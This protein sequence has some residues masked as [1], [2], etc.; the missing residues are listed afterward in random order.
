MVT[1]SAIDASGIVL[2]GNTSVS[3]VDGVANF[4][5]LTLSKPGQGVQLVLSSPGLAGEQIVSV[6]AASATQFVIS[7]PT[8]ISAGGQFVVTVTA[9]DNA[10][11]IADLFNGPVSVSLGTNPVGAVLGGVT[12][13]NAVNGVAQFFLSLSKSGSGFVLSASGDGLNGSTPAF[14]VGAVSRLLFVLPPGGVTAGVPFSAQV[15]AEDSS[16]NA[17]TNFN[18]VVTLTTGPN[19][20]L[21]S[22]LGSTAFLN[23]GTTGKPIT[24]QAVNGVSQFSGL[25]LDKDGTYTLAATS[26]SAVGGFSAPF[27]VVFNVPTQ[28]AVGPPFSTASGTSFSG[29]V[30]GSPFSTTVTVED[31]FG[32]AV[33]TFNGPLSLALGNNPGGATLGGSTTVS[34]VGGVATFA[35]LT[36]DKPGAGYTLVAK[37]GGLPAAASLP[38]DV[39]ALTATQLVITPPAF[40]ISGQPFTVTVAATDAAGNLVPSFTGTVTLALGANTQQEQSLGGT[41]TVNAFNGV[42]TFTGLTLSNQGTGNTLTATSGLLSGV[43][44]KPFAVL[45]GANAPAFDPVISADG[46]FIAFVSGSDTLV[47]LQIASLF[48]NVFLY[49]VSTGVNTLVSMAVSGPSITSDGNSD[50]P[51]IDSDGSFVAYR[52]EASD[53]TSGSAS[54]LSGGNIFEYNAATGTNTLVSFVQNTSLT[55]GSASAPAIAGDGSRIAYLST[56]ADLVPGQAAPTGVPVGLENVFVYFSSL[57]ENVLASGAFGS[58]TETGNASAQAPVLSRDPTPGFGSF[59]TDLVLGSGGTNQVYLNVLVEVNG[60]AVVEL[61][62]GTP[63]GADLTALTVVEPPI[64]GQVVLPVYSLTSASAVPFALGDLD[65]SG[66]SLLADGSAELQTSQ[67]LAFATQPGGGYAFAVSVS[68]VFGPAS[69][70][71]TVLV[72]APP[73]PALSPIADQVVAPG[74]TDSISFTVSNSA[75]TVTA[76]VETATLGLLP[77][78]GGVSVSPAGSNGRTITLKP[79]AGERGV[80]TITLTASANGLST[81]TSF[82]VS[83]DQAP[84]LPKVGTG[85]TVTLPFGQFPFVAA[86]E[87]TSPEG[88]PLTYAAPVVSGDSLL[89]DIEEQYGFTGVGYVTVGATAYVLHSNQPGPGFMGYYLIRPSDGAI[90]PYDSTGNYAHA[91]ANRTAVA[92]V[93]ARVFTDPALLLNA[94]PPANYSALQSLQQQFQFNPVALVTAGVPAFVV[95]SAALNSFHNPYY[96][97]RPSDGALFAYDGS[98]D[99]TTSFASNKPIATLG[100]N[101]SSFPTEL[102]DAV[103]SPSLYAQLYAVN[104]LLD[105]HEQGGSFDTNFFGNQAEWLYSP[106]LNQYGEHYYTLILSGGQSVLHAWEGYSDSAVGAVVA[107]FNTPAVYDNPNLLINATYLPGPRSN[108]AT[109]TPSGDLTINLPGSAFVGTFEVTVSVSDGLL[110]AAQTVKVTSTDTAPALSI[111]QGGVTVTAGSTLAVP[112]GSFP[113]NDSVTATSAG[114]HPLITTTSVTSF[115]Q[116]LNLEQQLR[117]TFVSNVVAGTAADVFSAAGDNSFG[118]PY[119]LLNPAGMLFAYS[120][121]NNYATSFAGTPVA[122]LNSNVYADPTLLTNAQPPVNYANLNALQS[123]FQFTVAGPATAGA[124]PVL[125]LQS[126]QPGKGVMGFYLLTPNGTLYAYD[127][128]SLTTTISNSANIVG[129]VEPGVF[130]NPGLLINATVS[131]GMYPLLQQDEQKFDLQE[132]PDGFHTGLMGNAAKWLFS[133]IPNGKNQLFYTLVLSAGGTQA[134]LYEWDG[135]SNSVPTGAMPVAVLDPSVYADP[136]LLL[137]AAAPLAANGLTVNGGTTGVAV[138][139]SLALSAPKSF[140]GACQVSVTTTDGALTTTESFQINSTDTAPVP[141]VIP[142]RTVKAA[143]SPLVVNLSSTDAENDPVTYTATVAGAPFTLQQQYQFTGVGQFTTTVGG[144]TTTAYVLQ[145][146]VPGGVGGYY[147]LRSDGGVYAYDGSG[148]FS[149]TFADGHNQVAMLSPAVFTTPA[150]LTQATAVAVAQPTVSGSTVSLDVSGLPPGTLLEVFVTAFD[151]AES[152]RTSFLVNVTA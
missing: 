151:G 22:F 92:T 84:V 106:I 29:L 113:L 86:L 120:G 101:L 70:P 11:D 107:T 55:A 52:S 37:G 96:L 126:S 114:N 81:Q 134:Q 145:S 33:T 21:D 36:L 150:L 24:S 66:N 152:T 90:F 88:S 104:Q 72:S 15:V 57:K 124:T 28:L 32:N 41:L 94:Q 98:G 121:G 5:G 123:Q 147:L 143:N 119:Y 60:A 65:A 23:G 6:G 135:G 136:T 144:V 38:F 4:T 44:A 129:T 46:N 26:P 71:F 131:P 137:N 56:A 91:F 14:G 8:S 48:T 77:V 10:G 146:A 30:A 79:A 61:A 2:G 112:H 27:N 100:P 43:T 133:P 12:T 95:S 89:F 54:G 138:N 40:V 139:G 35:N 9:E 3:T 102:T 76:S 82:K 42:A 19:S 142:T 111:R 49:N 85:D 115:S 148:D 64:A 73:A 140:V 141:A 53:L 122:T 63:A 103:A 75:A 128:S 80:A 34:A 87:A 59:A 110:S 78:I 20:P 58:F 25:L 149:T 51:V 99:F 109:V 127:G 16:G 83:V 13:V 45:N 118:N 68:T 31:A 116:F 108:T 97:I 132:L 18:D 7:E 93:G 67:S 47:P 74:G 17:I 125:A 50:S 117:L 130:V 1:V 69:L 105:L 39:A 62:N